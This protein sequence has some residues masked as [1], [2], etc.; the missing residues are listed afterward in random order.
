MD[1]QQKLVCILDDDADIRKALERVLNLH[2]YRCRSFSSIAEFNTRANYKEAACLILDIHLNGESGI[3]LKRQ[4]SHSVP[5]LPVI[6]MTGRDC[7][8]NREAAKQVGGAGY[9]AKPFESKAL[10]DLLEAAIR[11][12]S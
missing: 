9:L 5:A 6:F 10:L 12:P 11:S 3:D 2:G 4:L 7:S 1:D 8:A